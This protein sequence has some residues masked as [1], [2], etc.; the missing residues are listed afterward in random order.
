MFKLLSQTIPIRTIQEQN[1]NTE[2]YSERDILELTESM[3]NTLKQ[4]GLSLSEIK[5]KIATVEPFK[6]NL[7]T[8]IEF[9]DK[10]EENNK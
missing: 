5:K 4:Q 7:N 8:V 10:L 9:F 2:S 3:Y 1:L 6:E